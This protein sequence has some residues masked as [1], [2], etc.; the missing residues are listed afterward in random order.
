[1]WSREQPKDEEA[2]QEKQV[3]SQTEHSSSKV[4]KAIAS[5][6]EG[7]DIAYINE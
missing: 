3:G 4:R 7:R 6:S 2:V 5:A 1:M